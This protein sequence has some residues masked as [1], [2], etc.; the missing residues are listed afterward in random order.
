[1]I[2]QDDI[3]AMTPSEV[4][5][6]AMADEVIKRVDGKRLPKFR[7]FHGANEEWAVLYAARFWRDQCAALMADIQE[8][9]RR[10]MLMDGEE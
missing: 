9:Q 4:D 2:S 6:L 10:S 7:L 3:D 1:M 5:W 8:A